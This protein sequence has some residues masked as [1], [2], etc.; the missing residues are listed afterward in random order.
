MLILR[1]SASMVDAANH[2]PDLALRRLLSSR[3]EGLQDYGCDLAELVHF[4]VIEPGDSLDTIETE[5]GF[6]PLVNFAVAS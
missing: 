5:L 3:I 4:F 1:D 2:Q 6:S